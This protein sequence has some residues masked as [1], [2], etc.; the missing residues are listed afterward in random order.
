MDSKT[1]EAIEIL[2]KILAQSIEKEAKA[3]TK[4]IR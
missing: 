2:S 4:K 1:P 3:L